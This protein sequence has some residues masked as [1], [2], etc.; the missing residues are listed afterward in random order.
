MHT[1]SQKCLFG[2]KLWTTYIVLEENHWLI[3]PITNTIS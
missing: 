1:K 2:R 3:N